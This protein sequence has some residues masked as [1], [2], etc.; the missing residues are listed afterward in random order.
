MSFSSAPPQL[1]PKSAIKQYLYLSSSSK[2]FVTSAKS[3]V[4]SHNDKRHLFHV[5]S[6][7]QGKIHCLSAHTF[8]QSTEDRLQSFGERAGGEDSVL[9]TTHFSGSD[10]LHRH[11]N[12]TSVLNRLDAVTNSCYQKKRASRCEPLNFIVRSSASC[13]GIV[14][15]ENIKTLPSNE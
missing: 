9:S 8:D 12:L 2:Y 10:K 14:Y 11:G 7:Q 4:S 1:G 5:T 13:F 15:N 3:T 6:G